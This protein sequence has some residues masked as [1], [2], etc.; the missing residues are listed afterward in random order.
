MQ[1]RGVFA[2]LVTHLECFMAS[3]NNSFVMVSLHGFFG[4][5]AASDLRMSDTKVLFVIA[6]N[7]GYDGISAC[8]QSRIAEE[9]GIS[10]SNVPRSLAKLVSYGLVRKIKNGHWQINPAYVWRGN[11][12]D[13]KIQAWAESEVKTRSSATKR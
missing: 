9:C 11:D 12:R 10:R 2:S 1:N 3:N 4:Q 13:R 7:I 5:I 8:T 6:E